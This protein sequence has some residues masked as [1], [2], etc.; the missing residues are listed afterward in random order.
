MDATED[1]VDAKVGDD[2]AEECESA[3]DEELPR[4]TADSQRWMHRESIY[5]KANKTYATSWII[6]IYHKGA[7]Q[8]L[9]FGR[10]QSQD[11]D[12]QLSATTISLIQYNVL[13]LVRRIND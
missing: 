5:D 3:V 8:Y 10:S 11:V 9:Y 7:I 4:L 1:E 2:D 12:A 6:E 13:S